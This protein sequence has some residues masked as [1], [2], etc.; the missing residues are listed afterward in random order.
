MVQQT[1]YYPVTG[2][3][4]ETT[5]ALAIPRGRCIAVQNYESVQA[6]YARVGGFERFDGQPSPTNVFDQA[7]TSVAIA[8]R[9][10]ARTAIQQ[11]PG[12]G[13][14]RGAHYFNGVIYAWRDNVAQTQCVMYRS[15]PDGWDQVDIGYV[16]DFNS[17][18]VAELM[19]GDTIVGATTAAPAVVRKVVLVS[20]DW[21][22]GDAAG[23]LV[24]DTPGNP[25]TTENI[26][27]AGQT[28]VATLTS[29]ATAQG[30]PPGG[31]YE[32]V[33]HNF[34]ATAP[35]RCFY[36]VNGV[37][38]GFEVDIS[39]TVT[40]IR[41]GNDLTTDKPTS[42][43][44]HKN[45]LFFGFP[46]GVIENSVVGSPTD[47]DGVVGA[48]EIGLG[49]PITGFCS[50]PGSAL[51]IFAETKVA[52]L[53]GSSADDWTLDELT[54]E[55]GGFP[56]TMQRADQVLYM[57]N[58]GVRSINASRVYGNFNMATVT[59][60]IERTLN[61]KSAGGI[62]PVASCVS[63]AKTQYRLFFSDGTGISIFFGR[64]YPECMAFYYGGVIP[65]VVTTSKDELGDERMFFGAEDGYVYEMDV[66]SSFDGQTVEAFIQLPFDHEGGPL[67][68]K[69]WHK[70]TL[71]MIAPPGTQI[72]IAA[73]FDYSSTDQPG[74]GLTDLLVT[75]GLGG[76]WSIDDWDGFYWSAPVAG[77]AENWIDG[78]GQNMSIIIVSTSV[79]QLPYII[80]GVSKSFT[81]RGQRR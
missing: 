46:Q 28:N 29:V 44:V 32:L 54:D 81:V 68:L 75:G 41:T 22:N 19:P 7:E 11:V 33:T 30:F 31:K 16:V 57:D 73:E 40:F 80:Q 72:A 67:L 27:T 69:K 25:L 77:I 55:G 4:D 17:G 2:G 65:N 79:E 62:V 43:A 3:L 58:E 49:S 63:K 71:E 47:W 21:A 23:Y 52:A 39:G 56:Y 10:A 6:G 34:Y 61:K 20:G 64:K 38:R 53:Y 42:I 66:G 13:P 9:E 50:A 74:V 14:V 51:F 60:T 78:Q 70:V 8:E 12:T 1:T 35:L 45:H 36:G 76:T 48:G 18:G 24:L 15:S 37:G 26:S 5:Q 59:A